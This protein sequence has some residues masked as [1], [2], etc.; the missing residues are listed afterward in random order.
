MSKRE[1]L[2]LIAASALTASVIVTACLANKLSHKLRSDSVIEQARLVRDTH[3]RERLSRPY[4]KTEIP[5]EVYIGLAQ[6]EDSRKPVEIVISATT[7]IP[8]SLARIM[9]ITPQEGT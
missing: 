2:Y 5:A 4:G 6:S 1:S 7:A 8:T 9:L 3:L